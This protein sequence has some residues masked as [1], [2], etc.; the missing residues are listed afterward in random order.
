[1]VF[2]GSLRFEGTEESSKGEVDV[3]KGGDAVV[4]WRGASAVGEEPV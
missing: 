2:V 4:D 3:M 1:M